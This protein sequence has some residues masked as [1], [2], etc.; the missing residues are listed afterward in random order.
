MGYQR[1]HRVQRIYGCTPGFYYHIKLLGYEQKQSLPGEQG[2]SIKD[3]GNSKEKVELSQGSRER[4]SVVGAGL[5]C[6]KGRVHPV[7]SAAETG[8]G[9]THLQFQQRGDEGKADSWLSSAT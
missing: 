6:V 8:C 2:V 7:P 3:S 4:S 5:V 1:C 9:G